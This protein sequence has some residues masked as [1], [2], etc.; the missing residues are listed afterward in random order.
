V[1][2]GV[3]V[4]TIAVAVLLGTGFLAAMLARIASALEAMI[5]E[6]VEEDDADVWTDLE[7]GH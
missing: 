2:D 5:P 7:D 6:E 4:T 1:I 3:A